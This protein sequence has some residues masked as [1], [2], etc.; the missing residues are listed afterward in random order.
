MNLVHGEVD[1]T[2]CQYLTEEQALALRK[3]LAKPGEV[4]ISHEGKMG[5]TGLLDEG[6]HRSFALSSGVT[7]YH[8]KD[9]SRLEPAFLRIYFDS[10]DF[11]RDE[12]GEFS[13][14]GELHWGFIRFCNDR[15]QRSKRG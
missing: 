12:S 6:A 13:S 1:T 5:R 10:L 7:R 11:Q 4:L 15:E 14:K 3:G 9:K 8:I 2:N